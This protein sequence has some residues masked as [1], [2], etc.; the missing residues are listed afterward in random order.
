M[1]APFGSFRS[2]RQP[3]KV[4]MNLAAQS[5]QALKATST[6]CLV[7]AAMLVSTACGVN[8]SLR[9]ILDLPLTAKWGEPEP[10][11]EICHGR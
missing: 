10:K 11:A 5:I 1:G 4:V 3:V 9:V 7:R 6:E 8:H 2:R